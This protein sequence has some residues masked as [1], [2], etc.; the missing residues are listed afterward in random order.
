MMNAILPMLATSASPFD[1]RDYVFEVKW[2]GV[3]ALAA[4]E[5]NGWRL[6]GRELADYG[7]RY[8]ELEVLRSLPPGTIVDGELVVF[9]ENRPNLN[10]ILRRH[11]LVYPAQV[12]RASRQMRVNY[13]LFDILHYRS[14][15]LMREP[16]TYRRSLLANVLTEINAPEL[17]FSEGVAEFG[18]AFFEQVVAKDHEGVMAKHRNSRYLPGTR[19]GAWKKIKPTQVLPCVI[20]GYI[21]GEEGVQSILVATAHDGPLRYVGQIACGFSRQSRID[22]L[23]LLSRRKRKLSIVACSK[24]AIWVEPEHYCRVR[25]LRWTPNGRMRGASFAGLIEE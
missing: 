25:F 7:G 16:L 1:S 22:L 12:R 9:Q 11:Q 19:S 10:A 2:D 13:V 3:R 24:Q 23:R 20:I 4:V 21:L 8:P 14:K 15:P 18:K 5:K 6:W 17:V